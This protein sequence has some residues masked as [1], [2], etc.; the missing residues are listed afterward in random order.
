M[1]HKKRRKRITCPN[2]GTNLS[3]EMNFCHQCGQENHVKRATIKMLTVDFFS[4]YFTVDSKLFRSLKFLLT[5]PSFLSFEYLN[6]KIEAYIRP[7]RLY[8][9]ISFAYF[10]LL[11]ITSS[12]SPSKAFD[13]A[14]SGQEISTEQL[15]EELKKEK[16]TELTFSDGSEVESEFE[17]EISDKFKKIFSDEREQALFFNYLRSKL[18]ILLFIII[19]VFAC[20]LFITFYDKECYYIDHLVFAMHLQAYLFVMLIIA[21]ILNVIFNIDLNVIAFLIF[22]IYGFIAAKRFYKRKFLGT[23]F[24][25][26]LAGI[27]HCI[28]SGII[29]IIFFLIV[30]KYYT[31]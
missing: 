10:L 26:S 7:M 18:P 13:V 23:F 4:S 22:L 3:H 5:K 28:V 29:M 27:M 6:G 1:G 31:V 16:E 24:R 21:E 14:N 9:F 19:P 17:K 30:V 11:G 2:C 15:Q 12:S 8:V 25:L 20:L